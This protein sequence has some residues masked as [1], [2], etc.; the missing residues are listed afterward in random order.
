MIRKAQDIRAAIYARVSSDQQAEAGTIGSQ[1]E[2]LQQRV[3][4]DGLLLE[5]EFCFLDDG[6]TGATLIR[7]ALERLRDV[8]ATGA[9][10]RLYVH[11]PDRLAQVRLSGSAGRR[12][13]AMRGGT[14][15]PEPR[16]G[17]HAGGGVAASGP[18]HGGGIRTGEDP[19]AQPAR[20][21]PRSPPW[22]SQCSE[23]GALRIPLRSRRQGRPGRLPSG[24]GR[25]P[26][27][28][29]G[30]PMG[31]TGPPVDR[32]SDTPIGKPRH[33]NTFRQVVL[34][35][36]DDLGHVEESRLQGLGRFRQDPRRR[37]APSPAAT[38]QRQ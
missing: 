8:A 4:E 10:D 26:R 30:L 25:G 12:V 1:V 33:S 2:A 31:G 13:E 19:G 38:T 22:F 32:R 7:P 18:G 36:N 24:S 29:A 5:P 27:G 23:R 14:D 34:G 37:A 35:S 20:Q 21:A 6:Y 16:T 11:C 17:P 3:Q 15:L 9:I 28:P